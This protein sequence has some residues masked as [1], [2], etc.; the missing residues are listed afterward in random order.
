VGVVLR[1][2]SSSTIELDVDDDHL[3]QPEEHPPVDI[4]LADKTLLR[5][6]GRIACRRDPL[7]LSGRWLKHRLAEYGAG[8][9]FG[10]GKPNRRLLVTEDVS[11]GHTCRL[12]HVTVGRRDR[13]PTWQELVLVKEAFFGRDVDAMQVLPRRA[14]WNNRS[15][16]SLHLWSMPQPWNDV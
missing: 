3:R 8:Q 14:D 1:T 2:G 15:E 4:R 7:D 11:V 5:Y 9:W 10:P 6:G 16:Y 13:L 12:R